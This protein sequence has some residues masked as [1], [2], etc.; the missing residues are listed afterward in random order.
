MKPIYLAERVMLASPNSEP[1]IRCPRASRR[2]KEHPISV[3]CRCAAEHPE[4]TKRAVRREKPP[5]HQERAE[6]HQTRGGWQRAMKPKRK[7]APGKLTLSRRALTGRIDRRLRERD[8][9]LRAHR[10][11]TGATYVVLDVKREAVIE[12]QQRSRRARA[13]ALRAAALGVGV[14]DDDPQWIRVASSVL[15]NTATVAG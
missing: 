2:T 3:P 12:T 11:R 6:V 10:D 8:Q 13:Q 9:M 5:G 15:A 4:P 14:K 1:F 7:R